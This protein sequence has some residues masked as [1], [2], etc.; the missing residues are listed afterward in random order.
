MVTATALRVL[1]IQASEGAILTIWSGT[2]WI[3]RPTSR[4]LASWMHEVSL[5]KRSLLITHI[6]LRQGDALILIKGVHWE[7]RRPLLVHLIILLSW[8]NL[9]RWVTISDIVS[10]GIRD[11]TTSVR[12]IL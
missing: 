8:L 10:L 11:K 3:S 9:Q 1:L 4:T 5:L 2:S 6:I 7:I 12:E